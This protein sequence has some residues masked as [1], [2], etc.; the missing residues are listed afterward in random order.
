ML[1]TKKYFLVAAILSFP[2]NASSAALIDFHK[3]KDMAKS[4]NITDKRYMFV[5]DFNEGNSSAFV[6]LSDSV[7]MEKDSMVYNVV[8]VPSDFG[9]VP[10]FKVYEDCQMAEE[11]RETVLEVD[12]QPVAFYEVCGSGNGYS[13]RV[14]MP[15]TD[16]GIDFIV[17]RFKTQP[18]VSVRLGK[19]LIPFGS[20]GFGRIWDRL[21][22]P[23]L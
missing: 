23:A 21:N 16:K 5:S 10:L 9:A 7:E 22:R 14:F 19:Y 12:G 15:R 18:F 11:R 17:K 20:E 6:S 2:L 1:K 4:L 3:E 13:Q 8:L